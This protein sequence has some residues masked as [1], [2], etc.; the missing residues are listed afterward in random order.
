MTLTHQLLFDLDTNHL[1]QLQ[2]IVK[3]VPLN[4]F[5]FK[6]F[7]QYVCITIVQQLCTD[8]LKRKPRKQEQPTQ[9]FTNGLIFHFL[10]T[11]SIYSNLKRL[12][13]VFNKTYFLIHPSQKVFV[14]RGRT[15]PK[16][17]Y[18]TSNL[19]LLLLTLRL[20][21][22]ENNMKL[23]TVLILNTRGM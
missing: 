1:V 8:Y 18:S 3:P 19:F 4:K 17:T 7:N 9:K 6:N 11:P 22:I 14:K 15:L 5:W 12:F 20:Y 23:L 10:E 2:D 21:L 16:A 13:A